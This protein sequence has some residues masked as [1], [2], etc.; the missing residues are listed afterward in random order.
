MLARGNALSFGIRRLWCALKGRRSPTA[1]SGR[2]MISGHHTQGVALG[3]RSTALS[4]PKDMHETKRIDTVSLVAVCM[5]NSGNW[6]WLLINQQ[7]R[8]FLQSLVETG[9]GEN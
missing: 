2:P 1:L 3:W 8:R 4:A 7:T 9:S 5:T 6:Q